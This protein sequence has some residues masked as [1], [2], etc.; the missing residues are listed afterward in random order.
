MIIEA[1]FPRDEW[2]LETVGVVRSYEEPRLTELCKCSTAGS[3]RQSESTH[4][5]KSGENPM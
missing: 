1:E 3:S 2:P 5:H 4:P